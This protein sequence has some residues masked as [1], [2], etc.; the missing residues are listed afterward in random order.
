MRFSNCWEAVT[1]SPGTGQCWL[2]AYISPAFLYEQKRPWCEKPLHLNELKI[3]D[4]D[5]KSRMVTELAAWIILATIPHNLDWVEI[6]PSC[7]EA[8]FVYNLFPF[9]Y[10]HLIEKEKIPPPFLFSKTIME[11][12]S[13]TLEKGLPWGW[14]VI[15]LHHLPSFSGKVGSQL[16]SRIKNKTGQRAGELLVRS[17]V[18]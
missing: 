14:Q 3:H 2:A 11:I 12:Y 10:L 13:L 6:N 9:Y 7:N 5:H 8:A 18:I 1:S 15:P 17:V 16:P 4:M